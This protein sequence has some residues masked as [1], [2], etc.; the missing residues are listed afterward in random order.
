[1]S[2]WT[3]YLVADSLEQAVAALSEAPGPARPVA[4]GTDLLLEI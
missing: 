3:N 4:G 1:M 2:T